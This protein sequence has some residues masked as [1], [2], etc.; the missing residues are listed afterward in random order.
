M[1]IYTWR[2]GTY[3]LLVYSVKHV[4]CLNFLHPPST[5][6]SKQCSRALSFQE[7]SPSSLLNS[8]QIKYLS[9]Y[10]PL[11]WASKVHQMTLLL[12]QFF[13]LKTLPLSFFF[14]L[15]LCPTYQQFLSACSLKYIQD[16]NHFLPLPYHHS[17]KATVISFLDLCCSFLKG[18]FSLSYT[19]FSTQQ[20]E[21]SW[22]LGRSLSGCPSHPGKS[23]SPI[24][25]DSSHFSSVSLPFSSSFPQLHAY[26][27]GPCCFSD[28]SRWFLPVA[29]CI[30]SS[31]V[32]NTFYWIN[33]TAFRTLLNATSSNGPSFCTLSEATTPS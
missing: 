2:L 20:P 10:Q 24:W 25:S 16:P 31:S 6:T 17:G 29:L 9:L 8:T 12:T 22:P 27:P 1:G 3:S 15:T 4:H 19:V 30:C 23:Q 11:P 26:G 21:E 28:A 5:T 14:F 13:R 7:R 33:P 18:L 32:W